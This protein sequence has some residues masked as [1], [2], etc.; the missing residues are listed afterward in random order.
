LQGTK[1]SNPTLLK[2]SRPLELNSGTK[3]KLDFISV[4]SPSNTDAKSKK[5]HIKLDVYKDDH[6][7]TSPSGA[8][9]TS[10]PFFNLLF[11]EN[12]SDSLFLFHSK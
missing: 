4:N 12:K 9:K 6:L 7:S 5:A 1:L 10:D 2:N 3:R 11:V 8:K